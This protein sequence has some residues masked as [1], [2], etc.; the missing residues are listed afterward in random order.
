MKSDV[1]DDMDLIKQQLLQARAPGLLETKLAPQPVSKASTAIKMEEEAVEI[2]PEVI[3]KTKT[4]IKSG[5]RALFEEI[6]KLAKED[7]LTL[8]DLEEPLPV[9]AFQINDDV[10]ELLADP[11]KRGEDGINHV[12]CTEQSLLAFYLIAKKLYD[13]K[14]LDEAVNAFILLTQI[15]PQVSPFW[16]GLGIAHE[17]KQ[18]WPE[19][20]DALKKAIEVNPD[21]FS[22]FQVLIR[23]AAEIHDFD[24]VKQLLESHK[25]T[26]SIKEEVETA[27]QYLPQIMKG[28]L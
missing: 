9:S 3:E 20:G 23:M 14:M 11:T 13:D 16:L 10:L 4:A 19:A 6:Q 22:P 15:A 12:G 8:E 24:L 26:P 7:V 17:A 2:D 25:D 18:A 27:L 1:H 5:Y 21:D 28:G